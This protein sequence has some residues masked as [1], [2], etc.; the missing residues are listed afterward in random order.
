M[1]EEEIDLRELINV[2]L[3]RKWLIIGIFAIAVLSAGIINFFVLSPIYQSSTTFR[4]AQVDEKLLFDIS[5]LENKIKSDY[6]LQEVIK[7]LDLEISPNKLANLVM[8]ENVDKSG[9]IKIITE[10]TSP[11]KARDITLSVVNRFIEVNQNYY[12]EKIKLLQEEKKLLD[13]QVTLEKEKINEAEKLRLDIIGSKDLSLTEKQIQINLLLNYSTQIRTHYNDLVKQ[14]YE[15]E[16][17]ILNS[18]NFEIIN[19]PS[20]PESPIKPNKKLNIAIGGVLG[21]FI[22]TFIAF[23][24]EFWQTGKE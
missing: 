8:I 1:P 12:Q 5:D 22:G 7:E 2:L 4:I 6:I 3:K 10:D 15:L 13:K 24:I 20:V 18:S 17:Q 9:Y 11:E 16:N 21:L 23:F 14:R 19:Y